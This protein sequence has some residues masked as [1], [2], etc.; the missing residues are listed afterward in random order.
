MRCPECGIDDDK[1]V[2]IFN[3]RSV[4]TTSANLSG[5]VTLDSGTDVPAKFDLVQENGAW[6][7][8]NYSIGTTD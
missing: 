4:D 3:Q 7:L 6:K 2:L 1:V 8:L 5:S